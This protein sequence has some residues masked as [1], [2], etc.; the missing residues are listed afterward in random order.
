MYVTHNTTGHARVLNSLPSA[1]SVARQLGRAVA[2][3]TVI[4]LATAPVVAQTPTGAVINREYAIKAAFLY[5]FLNYVDW[6]A[7]SFAEDSAPFVIG[8]HEANPFDNV[9]N[10]VVQDKKVAGRSIEIRGLRSASD[11]T[12]CHILFVPKSVPKAMQDA[13]IKAA[14]G[15]HTLTVGESDDFI[16]RGGAARFFL[17]GNKVRFEF[18]KDVLAKDNLKVSSKL[19]ALAKIASDK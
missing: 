3:C 10:L 9:L 19:L 7:D 12:K 5:Q 4:I 15:S 18:N 8:V 2:L 11:V 6:P 17:E 14:H 1:N 13:V 16:D